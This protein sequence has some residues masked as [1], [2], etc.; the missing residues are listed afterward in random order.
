MNRYLCAAMLGVGS[1]MRT[2]AAPFAARWKRS[3]VFPRGAAVA[4]AG[5]LL[6]DKMPFA[7]P[8]TGPGALVARA[9]AAAFAACSVEAN[10]G[11]QRTAIVALAAACAVGSAFAMMSAR[12]SLVAKTGLPDP[13]VALL[14]D[15]LAIW[16]ALAALRANGNA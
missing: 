2:S 3:G 6:I 4:L 10:T 15:A 13:A 11:R 14:E 16:L 5:E 12:R 7:G 9:A 1:G 8:R